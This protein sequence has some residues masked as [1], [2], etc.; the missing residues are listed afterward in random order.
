MKR[1]TVPTTHLVP[2][3]FITLFITQLG[4][5]LGDL[6]GLELMQDIVCKRH[7]NLTTDELLSEDKCR[8]PDVQRALNKLNIGI[9][10]S[11]T[12]GSTS[13]TLGSREQD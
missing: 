10:I 4:L 5:S 6:P 2:F 11:A 8:D 9:S 1:Y 12:I 7:Y 3:L 13:S